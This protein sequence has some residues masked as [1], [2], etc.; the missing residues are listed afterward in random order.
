M[1]IHDAVARE[2]CEKKNFEI[3][4]TKCGHVEPCDVKRF[5]FHLAHGWPICCNTT[6]KLVER[7]P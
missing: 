7:K 6:M 4:C 1:N 3:E 2:V 5:A